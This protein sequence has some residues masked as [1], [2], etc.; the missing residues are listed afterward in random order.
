MRR[1][2]RA[3]SLSRRVGTRPERK[4][5]VVFCE[6]SE[7]EPAYVAGL[8]RLQSVRDRSAVVIELDPRHAVPL[9]LV[10]AAAERSRDPEVDEVWCI[11]DVEAPEQHPRLDEAIALAAASGVH[12][13]LSHPCFELWLLLHERD[14]TAAMTT[15]QAVTAAQD[16]AGVSG[17]TIDAAAFLDRR[18]AAARRSRLLD[19]RHARDGTPLPANPSTSVRDFVR[20]VD[21]DYT[22]E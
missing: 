21:P 5:V 2:A 6:G 20:A 18:F 22:D 7:T 14:Q 12:V 17:K 10:R 9:P 16:L 1:G 3:R 19:E 13:A 8:R 4:T 11:F 15:R